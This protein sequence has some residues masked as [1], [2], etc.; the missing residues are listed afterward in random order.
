MA[1]TKISNLNAATSIADADLLTIVQSGSNKK[2][3]GETFRN[4][5][6][7]IQK[8]VTVSSAQLLTLGSVPVTIIAA[9][10]AN[11]YL[12]ILSIC[13]SYNYNSVAY[14]F[15]NIESPSFYYGATWTGY[16]IQYTTINAGADFTINIFPY[17]ATSSELTLV[18]NT[19]LTL[20]T[21]AGTNPSTGNGDLDVVVYYSIEDVNT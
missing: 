3:T 15:S 2:I 7:Y 4:V 1:D 11:K 8:K 9:P 21:A 17:N 20:G 12:N 10:G 19:A 5:L 14:D 18:A 16:A 13:V 6:G